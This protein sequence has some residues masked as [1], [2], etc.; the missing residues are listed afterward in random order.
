[1]IVVESF[2]D[3]IS[4]CQNNLYVS[5]FLMFPPCHYLD[6]MGSQ[7]VLELTQ[8]LH[9]LQLK[10]TKIVILVFQKQMSE[11]KALMFIGI[12]LY[13]RDLRSKKNYKLII[14]FSTS[15]AN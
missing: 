9:V 7:D 12:F 4:N 1:M 3:L 8:L 14:K 11:T 10:V 13:Q 6:R 5:S 2:R 15:S